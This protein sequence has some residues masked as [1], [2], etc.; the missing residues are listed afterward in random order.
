MQLTLRCK[1]VRRDDLLAL[2]FD[3]KHRTGVHGFVIHE[4]CAGA[5]AS[6]ITNPLWS[7][8]LKFLAQS[9]EQRESRLK[10][11]GKPFAV[12]V[13]C[14]GNFA[15][16]EN[17]NLLTLDLKHSRAENQWGG[18]GESGDFQELTPGN[19]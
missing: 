15:G 6:T 5:A 3:R 19:S 9:I 1:S 2:S 17:V 7:C 16:A 18:R 11:C 4:N 13:Q 8:D 12:H 14:D 10:V